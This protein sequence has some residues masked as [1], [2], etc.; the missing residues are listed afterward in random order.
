MKID[1]YVL[2]GFIHLTFLH[3]NLPNCKHIFFIFPKR[4]VFSAF[5]RKVFNNYVTYVLEM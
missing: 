2:V 1:T 4:P 5:Y 3:N